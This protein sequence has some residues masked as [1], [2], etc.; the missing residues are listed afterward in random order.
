MM[1]TLTIFRTQLQRHHLLLARLGWTAVFL[2]TMS[3]FAAS[4]PYAVFDVQYYEWQVLEA[5]PAAATIFPTYADFVTYILVLRMVAVAVFWGTAVYLAWRKRNDWLVLY[6]S[7][8]L[9]MMSFLFAF[10]SDV[11]RWRF[12][13][14]LLAIFPAIEWL[15][16]TLFAVCFFL[17]F[18]L[19]PDGR[20][21]P[22]WVGLAG[23]MGAAASLFFF[24]S[25]ENLLGFS[26]EVSWILFVFCLLLV[27]FVGLISQ[28][29][30]WRSA[31]LMQKQQTRL[32]LLAMTTFVLLPFV[33]RLFSSWFV[34]AA[35]GHFISLHLFL[36]GATLIPLAIGVSVLRYRLWQM[37]VLLNRTLVYGGLTA[38]ILLLYG[39][40]VGGA[41]LLFRNEGNWLLA[42]LLTGFVAALFDPLR[43]RLQGGVNRLMYGQRDDPLTVLAEMGKRLEDTAVPSQTIPALVETIAHTLKLPY[44]AITRRDD[45][46]FVRVAAFGELNETASHTFPLIYQSETIGQLL[47]A[48]RS[49]GEA[50]SPAEMR[51]LRNVARQAGTAVYAAQLTTDLQRS[52][53]QLVIAREEE[54]RRLRRDL[55]DGLGPQLASLNLKLDAARNHLDHDPVTAAALLSELKRELHSAIGDIR[56]VAHD[57]RPPA[58][59]QLG[60]VSAVIEF[61]DRHSSTEMLITVSAEPLPSLPAAVEVAAYLI[62]LEAITNA[63]RHAGASHCAVFLGESNGRLQLEI[64]DDGH[65]LPDNY[66]AGV[67]L[68]S[69]RERTAELGGGF[70]IISTIDEGTA[71]KI[72][73]PLA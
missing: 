39:L 66:R 44:V 33:E 70:Q 52:R 2:L 42:V 61:A 29:I 23:V 26:E 35:W 45:D 22:R 40:V 49:V 4:L 27:A 10:Q 62:A 38:V 5:R 46:D 12:P 69:M 59:D 30:K 19:F 68:A 48:S 20:F 13:A 56:R 55:H 60:L 17:L 8:T 21:T 7:A 31:T 64:R 43:R 16:P 71:V 6:I 24:A 14:G 67:G 9:L 3:L 47:V 37:D 63:I 15:A 51:L 11:D 18:Y 72:T 36:L 54:R 32:V 25:L 65:G 57:L 50:F 34:D 53:E 28:V 1:T 73:L 58:L 41:G